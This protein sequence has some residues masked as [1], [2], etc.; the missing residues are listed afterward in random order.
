ML[1]AIMVQRWELHVSLITV[2]I[3]LFHHNLPRVPR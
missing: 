3:W 1:E 2:C